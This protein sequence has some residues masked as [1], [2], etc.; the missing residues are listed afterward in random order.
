MYYKGGDFSCIPVKRHFL[1]IGLLLTMFYCGVYQRVLL[2]FA[3]MLYIHSLDFPC[4]WVCVHTA[5][6]LHFPV[7]LGRQDVMGGRLC[8]KG[9]LSM[10]TCHVT[11]LPDGQGIYIHGVYIVA[12]LS[13][14]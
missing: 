13:M 14:F 6:V 11:D 2:G 12:Y 4:L 8:Y 10:E 1:V 9:R 3:G 7:S 5:L